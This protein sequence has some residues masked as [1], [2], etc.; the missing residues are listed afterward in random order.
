DAA[1]LGFGDALL[2]ALEAPFETIILGV[3]GQNRLDAARFHQLVEILDR[4]PPPGVEPD[5][6]HTQFVGDL[7]ALVCVLDLPLPFSR[8]GLHKV[9]VNR[10][11]DR[12]NAVMKRM[13]LKLLQISA[14]CRY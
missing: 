3:T 1:M 7:E 2:D 5:A 10:Q 9:L 11:A 12:S 13:A 4:V 8:I 6:R 14:V